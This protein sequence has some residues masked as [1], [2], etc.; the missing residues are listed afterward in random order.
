MLNTDVSD[1]TL[2]YF[3]IKK[4]SIEFV[5]FHEFNRSRCILI[6]NFLS[7]RSL[8]YNFVILTSS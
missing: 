7:F 1:V 3:F 4:Y 6:L 2:H 8:Q 5:E